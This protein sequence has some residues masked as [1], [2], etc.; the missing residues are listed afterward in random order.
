MQ[1]WNLRC[2]IGLI[3]IRVHV[4]IRNSRIKY[5]RR[6]ICRIYCWVDVRSRL[7]AMWNIRCNLRTYLGGS[8]ALGLDRSIRRANDIVQAIN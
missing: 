5:V 6:K 2:L 7:G 3:G 4:C 1:R 8:I